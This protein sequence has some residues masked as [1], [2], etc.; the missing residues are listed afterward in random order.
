MSG[1]NVNNNP[2]YNFLSDIYKSYNNPN[3]L[4]GNDI[5]ALNE[6]MEK[7]GINKNNANVSQIT[8]NGS[9]YIVIQSNDTSFNK[10]SLIFRIDTTDAGEKSYTD[11]TTDMKI[12]GSEEN[13]FAVVEDT[14]E[15]QSDDV[16]VLGSEVKITSISFTD[17]GQELAQQ[18]AT[19]K[20]AQEP[21]EPAKEPAPPPKNI[22]EI[23]TKYATETTDKAEIKEMLKTITS[24]LG[25][26]PL[27]QIS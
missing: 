21:V 12:A 19:Q 22:E 13:G 1:V 11:V 15:A 23:A 9:Q 2:D 25:T 7:A 8:S 16:Q 3:L 26:A 17:Y 5:T 18:I 20:T 24:H 10:K 14:Q 27:T 6:A 4:E